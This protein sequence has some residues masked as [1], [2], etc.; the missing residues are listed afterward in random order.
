MFATRG[1]S[2]SVAIEA[3]IPRS[4]L[5]YYKLNYRGQIYFPLTDI[6][7]LRFRTD[8][9]FG[10]G[11]GD[12]DTLPF[13]EHYYAGGFGSVRGYRDRSL[14]PREQQSLEDFGSPDPFG[15]NLLV[16]GGVEFIF[17]IPWVKDKRSIRTMLFLDGGNVFDTHRDDEFGLS[18]D[19][20]EFRYSA[21]IGLSWI[22]GIGPLTFS[23]A[24]AF[25]DQ[26]GDKTKVF[27]FSLGQPF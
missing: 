24:K 1:Y 19:P 15:G 16:E 14:G 4:E 11:Y 6:W 5:E 22:T 23:L 25:N 12:D 20:D 21:G 18:Y 27:Q 7:T 17:P 9:G 2:Q 13:F 3:S 8:I 26:S 10:D